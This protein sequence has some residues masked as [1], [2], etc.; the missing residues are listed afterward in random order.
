ML[1]SYVLLSVSIGAKLAMVPPRTQES[2]LRGVAACPSHHT[3][4]VVAV[5]RARAV[6]TA[7]TLLRPL[8]LRD[9]SG[10]H[11]PAVSSTESEQEKAEGNLP[12]F[13]THLGDFKMHHN[14][15]EPETV[16][17]ASFGTDT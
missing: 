2:G 8:P 16:L 15:G 4:A 14:I 9:M 13:E 17:E 3:L 11:Q 10:V 5:Q 6:D 1:L 12:T 7:T